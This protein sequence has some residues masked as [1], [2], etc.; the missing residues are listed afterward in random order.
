MIDT[1]RQRR[2]LA[3]GEVLSIAQTWNLAKLWYSNR[4][5]PGFHGRTAAQAEKLFREAGLT[6][7]YWSA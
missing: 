2:S 4:L 1:W 6:S 5:S 3:R 7:P